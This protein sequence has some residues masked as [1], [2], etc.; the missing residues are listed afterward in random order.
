MS[1]L[2]RY[3]TSECPLGYVC[4]FDCEEARLPIVDGDEQR[5]YALE[6]GLH[7]EEGPTGPS[8][9]ICEGLKWRQQ[10]TSQAHGARW[11]SPDIANSRRNL[12]QLFVNAAAETTTL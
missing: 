12:E 6:H 7:I 5:S 2:D 1:E 11:L 10:V 8:V 4:S 9:V 3:N